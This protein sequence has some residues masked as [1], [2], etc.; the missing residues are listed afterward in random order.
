MLDAADSLGGEGPRSIAADVLVVNEATLTAV[1]VLYPLWGRLE[2]SRRRQTPEG[3]LESA[4][5]LIRVQIQQ[6]VGSILIYGE[7]LARLEERHKEAL[8]QA[9]GQ[10]RERRIAIE[11]GGSSAKLERELKLRGLTLAQYDARLQRDLVVRDYARERLDPQVTLSRDDLL[12]YYEQHLSRF[13]SPATRELRLIEAPFARF[14]PEDTTWD[15]ATEALRNQARLKAL[16]HIRTAAETLKQHPFDEVAREYSRGLHAEQ[17]GSWG[18]I[19][20]PLQPPYDDLSRLIFEYSE[21][22]T[23]EP[24]ETPRGWYLVQCGKIEPERSV[25]FSQAQEVIRKELGEERFN[26]LA[27][28]FIQRLAAKAT[29]SN[30]EEFTAAAVRLAEARTRG[31]GTSAE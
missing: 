15:G 29:I 17:G 26:A 10:A 19:G 25:S 22:Q 28:T 23:S 4:R 30:I 3:F 1:E 5:R 9:V 13:Q 14:L 11:F 18:Q 6:D 31:T 24:I 21:G 20:K 27:N 16:R 2:E 12:Q 7:A 8:K